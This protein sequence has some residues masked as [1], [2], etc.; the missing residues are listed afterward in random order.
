MGVRMGNSYC[1]MRNGYKY[2]HPYYVHTKRNEIFCSHRW[3]SQDFL[4]DVPCVEMLLVQSTLESEWIVHVLVIRRQLHA[5]LCQQT[6]GHGHIRRQKNFSNHVWIQWLA[7][8]SFVEKLV[9]VWWRFQMYDN[10]NPNEGN[11]MKVEGC[12][13]IWRVHSLWIQ[14]MH[15]IDN[16]LSRLAKYMPMEKWHLRPLKRCKKRLQMSKT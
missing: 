4:Y 10:V 1:L 5:N 14:D 13:G 2:I 3:M 8:N 6:I 9:Y 11:R 12:L 7:R 15:S 16:K